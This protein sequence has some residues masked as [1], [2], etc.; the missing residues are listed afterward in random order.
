MVQFLDGLQSP[1][2]IFMS[3]QGEALSSMN[4]DAWKA[5]VS[6]NNT[7]KLCSFLKISYSKFDQ[8]GNYMHIWSY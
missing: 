6:L 2:I 1:V 7:Q 5:V 4:N 3:A 8:I